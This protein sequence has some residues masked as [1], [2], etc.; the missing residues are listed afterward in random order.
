MVLTIDDLLNALESE[1]SSKP[2]LSN[3]KDTW[4]RIGSRDAFSELGMNPSE[5]DRF[6]QEWID[7][8]PYNNI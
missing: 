1:D 7:N 5:L 8:N 4:S 2:T 3:T 6:L